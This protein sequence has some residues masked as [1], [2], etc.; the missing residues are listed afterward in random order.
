MLARTQSSENSQF[1]Q[2]GGYIFWKILWHCLHLLCLPRLKNTSHCALYR[3]EC[4]EHQ[5]PGVQYQEEQHPS[6][7]LTTT[8]IPMERSEEIDHGVCTQS[9]EYDVAMKKDKL[10]QEMPGTEIQA[11]VIAISQ[12]SQVDTKGHHIRFQEKFPSLKV[13]T[14]LFFS[15]V[16]ENQHHQKNSRVSAGSFLSNSPPGNWVHVSEN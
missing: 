7:T 14:A 8:Q 9:L 16:Q 11:S 5:D 4:T 13:R 12:T 3:G 10:L 15:L 2:V 6:S 1:L